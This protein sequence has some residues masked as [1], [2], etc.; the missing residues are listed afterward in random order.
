MNRPTVVGQSA[1]DIEKIWY[2]I[3]RSRAAMH[4]STVQSAISAVD[5]ALWDIVGQ[6]LGVPVYKLIGGKVNEKLRYYRSGGLGE[7]RSADAYRERAKKMAA[8][9]SIAVK[10][11]PF[12][13]LAG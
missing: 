12:G 5:I 6:K 9:G 2:D 11:D 4:G 8:E 13:R 7:V 10:F 3:S 1:W